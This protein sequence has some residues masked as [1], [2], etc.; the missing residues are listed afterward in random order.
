MEVLL[1]SAPI[2]NAAAGAQTITFN[3]HS[4]YGDPITGTGAVTVCSLAAG[5]CSLGSGGTTIAATGT[6][7]NATYTTFTAT[8]SLTTAGSYFI[9]PTFTSSS[10]GQVFATSVS[11]TVSSTATTAPTTTATPSTSALPTPSPSA[12]ASS[13]PS[14]SPTPLPDATTSAPS[15]SSNGISS[16]TILI[17][18]I[19]ISIVFLGL[20]VFVYFRVKKRSND[21]N[22]QSAMTEQPPSS[23]GGEME[24]TAAVASR[25]KMTVDPMSRR[26]TLNPSTFSNRASLDPTDQPNRNDGADFAYQRYTEPV[27]PSDQL[28][29]NR[30]SLAVQQ[31]T[32]AKPPATTATGTPTS[33]LAPQQLHEQYNPVQPQARGAPKTEDEQTG[34]YF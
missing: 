14:P 24:M 6:A 2:V 19:G 29:F 9:A 21:I 25:T 30:P 33:F 31:R 27:K 34:Y 17:I 20:L 15:T 22:S 13:S 4:A 10:N 8:V 32:R 1:L 3:V 28:L 16:T 7:I 18:G 26:A 12:S 5:A 11:A 23:G